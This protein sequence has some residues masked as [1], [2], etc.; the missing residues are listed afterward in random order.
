MKKQL[1]WED[2]YAVTRLVPM[3][4]VTT[5]GSIAEYLSLGS[6]RMVGWALN[7]CHTEGGI[8]PAQRVVNRNGELS[9]RLHF[10]TPTRM[11][12]LL[13]AEGIVVVDNK[14]KDFNTVFWHPLEL[15]ED[16]DIKTFVHDKKGMCLFC[17]V[18][19]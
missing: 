17:H 10:G 12:E 14:I 8:V 13:E 4:R 9:G 7:H 1:Y 11:Q 5:Y 6:A 18:L 19:R 15:K 2:V 3:G 16:A